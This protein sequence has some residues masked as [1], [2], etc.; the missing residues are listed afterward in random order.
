VFVE[1]VE[2]VKGP[3]GVIDSHVRLAT[4]LAI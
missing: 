4:D 1:D 2:I 3:K